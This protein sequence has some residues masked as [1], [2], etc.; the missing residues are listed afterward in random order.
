MKTLLASATAFLVT[1]PAVFA[2]D[3]LLG[4]DKTGATAVPEISALEGTAAVAALAA[5]VLFAWER[6]RRAA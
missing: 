4:D 5:I 1:A 2:Q 6:R 3:V